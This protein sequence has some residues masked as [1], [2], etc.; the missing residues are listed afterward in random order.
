MSK[1][2]A[3]K[4]GRK[5]GI[6][7]SWKECEQ[8]VKGFGNAVYKSFS[9]LADARAFLGEEDSNSQ[10]SENLQ[11]IENSQDSLQGEL[12]E[13][14]ISRIEKK[15]KDLSS[16]DNRAIAYVDGS[17]DVSCNVYGSGAVLFYAGN[18]IV[19][20]K[21]GEDAGL[22]SMRNVAG[23]ILAAEAVM[24]YCISQGIE[25]LDLY[26]DYQ[27]IEAWARGLWKANK[28]GTKEYKRF[29]DAAFQKLKVSFVKVKAHSNNMYNDEADAL[30]KKS[31]EDYKA[32]HNITKS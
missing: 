19:Y 31:I 5:T 16:D 6:F 10:N 26:Y 30:A 11:E 14:L 13:A 1:F 18:K 8:Q 32:E 3:V 22:V 7:H 2:Y 24:R 25:N 9:N 21:A 20:S 15:N 29:C 17:F 28:S 4:S 23:E 27:G 12:K